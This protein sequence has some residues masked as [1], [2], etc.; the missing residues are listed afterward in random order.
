MIIAYHSL[1]SRS[2]EI[3]GERTPGLRAILRQRCFLFQPVKLPTPGP[4]QMPGLEDNAAFPLKQAPAFGIAGL[5]DS[6]DRSVHGTPPLSGN[7][8]D[9]LPFPRTL[10]FAP[11]TKTPPYIGYPVQSVSHTVWHHPSLPSH[12]PIPWLLP[13]THGY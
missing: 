6:A 1:L 3:S 9:T 10:P 7:S 2:I 13:V 8:D 5:P 12:L 4:G 11:T